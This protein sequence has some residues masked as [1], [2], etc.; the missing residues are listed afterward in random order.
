MDPMNQMPYPSGQ[1]PKSSVGPIIAALIV[2][3]LLVAGAIYFWQE[4]MKIE[5]D[6]ESLQSSQE[7]SENAAGSDSEILKIES[8]LNQIDNED[9]DE[10][11]NQIDSEFT[12]T[13]TTN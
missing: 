9:E 7:V 10:N 12:S 6:M 11:V 13:S 4:R 8:D 1:A 3:A 5:K 2:V